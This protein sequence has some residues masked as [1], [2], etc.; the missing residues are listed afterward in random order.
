VLRRALDLRGLR[1]A[2]PVA[3]TYFA[4][5]GMRERT[6][7]DLQWD[8]EFAGA[9]GAEQL[10]VTELTHAVH[11]RP[12][13]LRANKPVFDEA[14]W[15]MLLAGLDE[16]GELA[17]AEGM[18]ICYRHRMGTGVQTRAEIEHLL[19]GTDPGRVRLA[20]DT[21]HLVWSGDDP[22]ELVRDHPGRIGHVLLK[23]L[24]PD[25]LTWCHQEDPS[26]RDAVLEGVFTVPGDGMI[27]FRPLLRA[28][29]DTGYTGWLVVEASQDP[30]KANPLAYAK[31]A[32][33]YLRAVTGR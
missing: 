19:A 4:S 32:R 17:A 23:D 25:V 15:T 18:R 28:L 20:L 5:A 33:E 8:L 26:F 31:K 12:V 1:V 27:D 3:Q 6:L 21:G 22:L 10:V 24:R 13:A 16:L 29:D 9:L 30:A 11:R 7:R 14:A 2:G